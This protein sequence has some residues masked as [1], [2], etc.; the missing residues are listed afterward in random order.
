M[1]KKRV[2]V[3]FNEDDEIKLYEEIELLAK[4]EKRSV[5]QQIKVMLAESANMRRDRKR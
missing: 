1:D 4:E 2:N 3:Y 5:N